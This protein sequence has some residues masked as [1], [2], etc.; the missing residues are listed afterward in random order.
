M[1]GWAIIVQPSFLDERTGDEPLRWSVA[2]SFQIS[3]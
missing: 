1:E 2:V 3:L